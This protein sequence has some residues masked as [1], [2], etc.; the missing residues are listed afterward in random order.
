MFFTQTKKIK[1]PISSIKLNLYN[2]LIICCIYVY[3]PA[4]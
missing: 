2:N 3:T 1:K 4:F